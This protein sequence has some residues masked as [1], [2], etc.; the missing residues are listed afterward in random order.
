MLLVGIDPCFS[1]ND[2]LVTVRK[3]NGSQTMYWEDLRKYG[4]E[5]YQ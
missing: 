3:E 1:C 5:Y 4:V 2:R